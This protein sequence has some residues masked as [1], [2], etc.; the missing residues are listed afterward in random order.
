M[1]PTLFRRARRF[2]D[3]KGS[4]AASCALACALFLT[5]AAASAQAPFPSKPITLVVGFTPGGSNDVIARALAPKL[6]EIL[7]VPVVVENKPGASGTIGTAFTVISKPDGHTITLGSTSVLSIGPHTIPNL[8]YQPSDLTAVTTVAASA[9]V[10]AINPNVPAKSMADLIAL[11]KTRPVSLASAGQAAF[12]ISTSSSSR[13]RRAATS[14]TSPTRV[15]PR[16]S[17][18]WWEAMSTASS[19]TT[20]RSRR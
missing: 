16:V 6:S 18:T 7:G 15:P 17:P 5:A 20:R 10:V 12:R 8:P 1:F 13:P 9:S 3:V 2:F 11:S 14:C 19:W 4:V